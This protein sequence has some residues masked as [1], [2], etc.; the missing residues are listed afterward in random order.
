MD[1]TPPK[2]LNER[3]DDVMAIAS[4]AAS[5]AEIA[6]NAADRA[7][8]SARA[9]KAKL[10]EMTRL[11][12]DIEGRPGILPWIASELA[13]IRRDVHPVARARVYATTIAIAIACG[14]LASGLLTCI[15]QGRLTP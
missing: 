3:L 8:T 12:P 2:T 14:A 15:A 1:R 7:D 9:T 6:T 4:I 5:R 10:D 13:A 11:T